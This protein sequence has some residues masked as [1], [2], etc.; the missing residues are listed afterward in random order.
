MALGAARR[1][2]PGKHR[3]AIVVS[4]DQVLAGSIDEPVVAVPL[5]SSA[6][7][8]ALRPE[9]GVVAGIDRPSCAICGA[10]RGLA[11]SRFVRRLGA[12]TPP[13]LS[14][15]DRALALILGLDRAGVGGRAPS[16]Q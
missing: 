13:V 4:D 15:V 2:E 1:G 16:T 12:L 7:R 8:S 3:A 9:I 11:R 6:Q 10:V 5:S 14:E